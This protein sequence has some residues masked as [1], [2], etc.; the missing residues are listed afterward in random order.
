MDA[1]STERAVRTPAGW[2]AFAFAGLVASSA[3]GF[4]LDQRLFTHLQP[5]R[6]GPRSEV[7]EQQLRPDE[8]PIAQAQ[9]RIT[10]RTKGGIALGCLAAALTLALCMA[11]AFKRQRAAAL[12]LAPLGAILGGA[13]GFGGGHLATRLHQYFDGGFGE[14]ATL[15][16]A[17]AVQSTAWIC[18]GVGVAFAV[19]L[20]GRDVRGLVN[21][22]AGGLLAGLLVGVLYAPIAAILFADFRT[23]RVFPEAGYYPPN[24]AFGHTGAFLFWAM[25][26]PTLFAA[27]LGGIGSRPATKPAPTVTGEQF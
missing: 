22:L 26:T 25:F 2:L 16:Q 7:A 5:Y 18:T 17:M 10:A 13:A 9:L 23:D 4:L 3:V 27:V 8:R 14:E 24:P 19:W 20:V 21:S 12:V 15:M 11:D 6:W 1:E